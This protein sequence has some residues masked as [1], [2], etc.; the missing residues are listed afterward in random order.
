[1]KIMIFKEA[2]QDV[3]DALADLLG[4]LLF[5]PFFIPCVFFLA[6]LLFPI[7]GWGEEK[8]DSLQHVQPLRPITTCG[9]LKQDAVEELPSCL[10]QGM[11]ELG[12]V[13]HDG[14]KV[15][16]EAIEGVSIH[17]RTSESH[18]PNGSTI[19][20]CITREGV[21][22]G[23]EMVKELKL[24]F[25]RSL[26]EQ[27][28]KTS[29]PL[30]EHPSSNSKIAQILMLLDRASYRNYVIENIDHIL[31]YSRPFQCSQIQKTCYGEARCGFKKTAS[32]AL[33]TSNSTDLAAIWV[34]EAAHL[35][36]CYNSE[37]Y[38][39][40]KELDFRKKAGFTIAR[41]P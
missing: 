16:P 5:H 38:A 14:S 18:S 11:E 13:D 19:V 41:H 26:S 2:R 37:E 9:W 3:K 7:F 40:E 36:G 29:E 33:W 6:S 27:E 34:H 15:I 39:L 35:E 30:S 25:E 21:E 12:L 17:I 8:R 20:W 28:E 23:E 31:L 22:M 4:L 32:L 24:S 10:Q 1:M